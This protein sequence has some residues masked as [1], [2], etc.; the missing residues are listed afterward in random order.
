MPM[1]FASGAFFPINFLPD[2]VRPGIELLPLRPFLEAL[3]EVL[4]Q[5]NVSVFDLTPNLALLA[6]WGILGFGITL[7]YFKWHDE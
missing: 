5:P 4:Q 3:R 6:C 1:V 2:W 7:R